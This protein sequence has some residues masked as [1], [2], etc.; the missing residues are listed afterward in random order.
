M[1]ELKLKL[2][3]PDGNT[4]WGE[5]LFPEDMLPED[6]VAELVEQ[7][8]LSILNKDGQRIEY[9]LRV[10]NRNIDLQPG[11]SLREQ[12]VADKDTL[13]LVSSSPAPSAPPK[14]LIEQPKGDT[15]EVILSVLDVNAVGK[16]TTF[17]LDM[18]VGEA[19]RDI[20]TNYKLP[21]R[22]PETKR[23]IDYRL[24]SK[25][26]RRELLNEETF[27]SARIPNRDRLNLAQH[28]VAG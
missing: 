27:R 1:G 20:I 28:A 9:R 8:D 6:V 18:A 24:S 19:I 11:K 21:V 12:Q 7:L 5:S 23:L 13:Q 3:S 10:V 2:L 4:L 17:N 16:P 25:A 22:D 26:H 14:P 15:V